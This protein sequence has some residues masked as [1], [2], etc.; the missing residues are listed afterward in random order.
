MKMSMSIFE[1]ELSAKDMY[2]SEFGFSEST[3]MLEDYTFTVNRTGCAIARASASAHQ[4]YKIAG[5]P[6]RRLG[7]ID[8]SSEALTRP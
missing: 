2:S 3:T 5:A 7:A 1:K 8:I 6:F 4:P